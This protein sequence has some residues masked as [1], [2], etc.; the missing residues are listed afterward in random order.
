MVPIVSRALS[1]ALAALFLLAI[2][3]SAAGQAYC[4][5]RDPIR[6]I[7][8]LFP[9][10]DSHVSIVREVS[11]EARQE[12]GRRLPFTLHSTELGTHTIYVA[13]H[14]GV[15]EGIVHVRSEPSEWG[16]VE[17]A[18]AIDTELRITGFEIQR[19]RSRQREAVEAEAFRNQLTGASSDELRRL[20]G[21][22]GTIRAEVLEVPPEA[23][24]LA[25]AL[26]RS[27]LKTLEVTP[28]VWAEDLAPRGFATASPV[29]DAPPANAE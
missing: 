15:A 13:Q 22:D 28:V 25:A 23:R 2:P 7:Y 8:R 1:G 6:S 12:V 26:V 5:L 4:A 9:D 20:I 19:C 29:G 27:G 18:W 14:D 21:S 24:V 16:L 3:G 11:N 17:V 10:A